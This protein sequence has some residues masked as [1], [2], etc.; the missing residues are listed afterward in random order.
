MNNHE[1]DN[2]IL[3]LSRNM[4][5]IITDVYGDKGRDIDGLVQ[6]QRAD[7]VFQE[8]SI[9]EMRAIREDMNKMHEGLVTEI[10]TIHADTMKRIA[11]VAVWKEGIQN[12]FS[13]KTVRLTWKTILVIL[14]GLYGAYQ[15]AI[16]LY[17]LIT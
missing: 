1:R 12:F 3:E 10:K 7:R 5:R 13:F 6:Q 16:G 8:Q 4:N 14:T 2:A 11:E 15:A 9:Q 17:N